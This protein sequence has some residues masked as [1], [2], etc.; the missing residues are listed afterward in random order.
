M[1][2]RPPVRAGSQQEQQH[3]ILNTMPSALRPG[4]STTRWRRIR[5]FVLR[6]DQYICALCGEGGA[7]SAG[8]ILA[9][10][11]GGDDSP[12]NLQAEHLVCPDGTGGNLSKGSKLVVRT[13]RGMQPNTSRTW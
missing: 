3:G 5:L 6:R 10:V 8:H 13:T 11:H 1:A 7:D 9:R 4:G 12:S 2:A